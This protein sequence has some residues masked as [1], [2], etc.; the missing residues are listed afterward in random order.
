MAASKRPD[1][2]EPAMVYD[3]IISARDLQRLIGSGT[4]VAIFD[5][6]HLLTDPEHGAR[7]YAQG[8]IP[9]AL[10]AHLD[11]DLAAPISDST[12]GNSG[13]HPLPPMSDWLK[14]LGAW[15]IGPDTQVVAYDD[16]GGMVASRMW[17]MLRMAGHRAAAVLDGGLPAWVKAG[18]ALESGA[19]T[20]P[21]RPAYPG[22][23]S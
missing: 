12:D 22:R 5:T 2:E 23:A 17:W 9:G 18:G 19:A 14:Q 10:F 1:R 16:A 6:R 11:R 8:H 13:R 7:A 15:G 21:A 4:D 20:R 3:T